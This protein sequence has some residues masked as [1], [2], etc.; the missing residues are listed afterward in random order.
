MP[1]M[2]QATGRIQ[3]RLTKG[4]PTQNAPTKIRRP[5]SPLENDNTGM[6]PNEPS[7]LNLIAKSAGPMSLVGGSAAIYT[8]LLNHPNS[9][10]THFSFI[11]MMLL[12]AQY[13]LQP[14]L[15]RKYISPQLNNQSVA[16]VEEVVKTGMAVV[17]FSAKPRDLI[18]DSLQGTH[19]VSILFGFFVLVSFLHLIDA[20]MGLS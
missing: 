17:L 10:L 19:T 7:V 12:A 4:A 15:S 9:T 20:I 8:S 14:R 11:F 13:A 18:Q 6:I 3:A 2:K 1:P 16:L 5:A